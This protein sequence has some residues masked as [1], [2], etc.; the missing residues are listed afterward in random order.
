MHGRVK[1]Q[2]T[3]EQEALK[4]KERA[5]KLSRYRIGMSI[6]FKKRNDKIYDEEL[7]TVTER[8]VKQNPDIYTL[9]NIRREAFTNND[10]DENLLEEYYQNELRLTEDCLKQNPKSYWVWYQRIWIMNHLV[11][12]DWKRELMLCTKYLNLDDRNFH[13]WNYREFVVQKA[14]ISPEEEFEFA[15][16]KILNNFSN[17][18]SWHYRSLLLSKIFHNSD[19]N[20]INEKKKQELDLVMNAT[21]T[22]PSDTSAWFYQRWLLDTHECLPILSQA[23]I[24]DNNVI[25]FANK[26]I[27]AESICLQINNENENVQWKSL[28]ETKI[29]KLWFGKFKK[30]LNEAKNVQ[31]EIEGILYPL[32]CVNQKWIY[33][34]R[35]YKSCS[36]KDQ[37]LEQLSSYKQ[38]VEMEPN[39]KWG[40]LTSILLMRKIDFIQ[41]Y[42]NILTNLNVL[43]N[44][45]SLRSNYYKDLR[46]KYII[47]YKISELWNIE[48]DQETEI[49]ID[50]SG[51][52]LT[53]LSNNEYLSFFEQINLSANYLSH[54]LNQLSL[55]QS[56]RKLSLSS[57]QMENLKEFPMLQ[58]LEVLS[59][60]NN[61]LN[62]LEEIL[63]LLTKHKLKLL[64]L[65]ENPIC[66]LKELEN[67]IIQINPDLQLYVE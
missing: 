9:W 47:E 43:V 51:L 25:L 56:C 14:Q 59:L 34:K 20:N 46:S 62:N 36:N 3:A 19:Q 55:L 35:K 41:F 39:N 65:R 23:L 18:S 28:Y 15:T 5:E 24:Q 6:V 49:E 26:N 7:M 50:L 31:I 32:L 10:W 2:T 57:N 17:Y 30:Q 60:R 27:L 67:S 16:S 1:V 21:F 58:N 54:S 44:I 11:N 33:R 12:C 63:Q 8:M 38:L 61:K 22:D 4:K 13:C 37:L 40:Y 64:D 48:E 42:E 66:N 52:N 29:S 45:D 53:T